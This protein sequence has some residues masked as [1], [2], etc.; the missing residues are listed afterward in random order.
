MA[1]KKSTSKSRTSS[2]S[3]SSLKWWY[4]L[5]VVAI[6][7]IAGYAIV[8]FS[9]AA[10]PYRTFTIGASSIPAGSQ[11]RALKG[12]GIYAA[13]A[14]TSVF[15]GWQQMQSSRQVCAYV[16][17]TGPNNTGATARIT[18]SGGPTGSRWSRVG[19]A[20][21]Q[22]SGPLC[23]STSGF[24]GNGV[25]VAKVEKISGNTLY[26]SEIYGTR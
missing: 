25:G 19:Y 15:V 4:V 20:T 24:P 11:G 16:Y 18:L 12:N 17:G 3:R 7:A 22:G 9:Q 10:G 8:R 26:I 13:S 1:S 21:Y 14:P 2:K 23:A 6:V 5:P